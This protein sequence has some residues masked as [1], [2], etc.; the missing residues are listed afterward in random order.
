M[1]TVNFQDILF[2]REG[3]ISEEKFSLMLRESL[4]VLRAYSFKNKINLRVGFCSAD[5]QNDGGPVF[6]DLDTFSPA[7]SSYFP[8]S[9][10][11]GLESYFKGLDSYLENFQEAKKYAAPLT[12]ILCDSCEN[13]KNISAA[14][15]YFSSFS[16]GV[17][18]VAQGTDFQNLPKAIS[19]N[20][21]PWHLVRKSRKSDVKSESAGKFKS[22]KNSKKVFLVAI[23]CTLF[24]ALCV[25]GIIFAVNL[26]GNKRI[27]IFDNRQFVKV[28][29][30]N[31]DRLIMRASASEDGYEIIRLYEDE[32][33]VLLD[34][35]EVW[36][37]IEY[38]GL[39]GFV[40]TGPLDSPWLIPAEKEE[41]EISNP[42]AMCS[43]G[44]VLFASGDHEGGIEY[45][46]MAAKWNLLEAKWN[47]FRYRQ[48]AGSE[49]NSFENNSF[50]NDFLELEDIIEFTGDF[51]E[52][53]LVKYYGLKAEEATLAGEKSV[54]D[55]FK[56]IA[57]NLANGKKSTLRLVAKELS[58][59][60]NDIE[61]KAKYYARAIDFG[62]EGDENLMLEFA[63]KLDPGY[64]S[65]ESVAWLN[66][67]M[68]AG[69]GEA[70]FI[71]GKKNYVPGKNNS[72][73]LGYFKKAA[74]KKYGGAASPY[75]CGAINF[76]QKNYKEAFDYF[77]AAEKTKDGSQEYYESL[78]MLG[79][80]YD[81]LYQTLGG[82]TK[83]YDTALKYYGITRGKVAEADAAYNELKSSYSYSY[84]GW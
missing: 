7:G 54:A 9:G 72:A 75:T 6:F 5:D 34:W 67:A 46:E 41:Y 79:F 1:H 25:S 80:F 69:S 49:N 81:P 29:T 26:I 39:H 82:V 15:A 84:Y 60:C 56:A 64:S 61:R 14:L 38:H 66:R 77:L 32:V 42:Q 28:C 10:L 24:G 55:N 52:D 37:E 16:S 63:R 4:Y 50:E 47:L 27:E 62:L 57:Y 11:D 58:E 19:Q 12:V 3:K 21:K 40:H 83:D 23:L 31:G 51:Y 73:A 65:A 18:I 59:R 43:Y 33:A 74:D 17:C 36:T 8:I 78:F 53:R 44:K 13:A 35:G 22:G 2:V 48:L 76:E 45:T 71:L 20:L 68:N 70:A 30:G